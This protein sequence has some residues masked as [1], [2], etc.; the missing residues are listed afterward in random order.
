MSKKESKKELEKKELLYSYWEK[1]PLVVSIDIPSEEVLTHEVR[2]LIIYSIRKGKEEKWINGTKRIRHSFSAKE[3]LDMANKKLEE[4]MK[5]QSMYFHI[6]KLQDFGL[7]DV[8]A[9][10]H[11]GRHN[12]AYFGRTARGFLFE[13]KKDKT[14]Y[15]NYFAEAGR[16]AKALN[17]KVS[18]DQFKD[19]LKEFNSINVESDKQLKQWLEE[20]AEFINENNIDSATMYS[21]LR[22]INYHNRKMTVLMEKVAELIGLEF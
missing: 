11:E 5:L 10:L 18:E 22:R 4:K 15:N 8:V 20:R 16:F 13:S 3:L 17:P 7:L 12:V 19:F 2:T 6:Q 21:F 14:K 1:L 9:T